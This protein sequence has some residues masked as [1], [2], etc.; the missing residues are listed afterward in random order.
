VNH[1]FPESLACSPPILSSISATVSPLDTSWLGNAHQGRLIA[2]DVG[3]TNLIFENNNV[4]NGDDCLMITGPAS[5]IIFR[6]S[7]CNGGHGLSVGTLSATSNV[8]VQNILY[9]IQVSGPQ[10]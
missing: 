5:N 1:S 2:F 4:Y 7:Y 8:V 3:G 10:G 9:V 6:N